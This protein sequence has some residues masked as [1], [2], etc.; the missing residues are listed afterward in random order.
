MPTTLPVMLRT[1][2]DFFPLSDNTIGHRMTILGG[3]RSMTPA[4]DVVS[5]RIERGLSVLI[6]HVLTAVRDA[7]PA[8][9]AFMG[10]S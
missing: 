9:A 6:A 2:K 8:Y 3:T 1:C 7:I 4:R 5:R 10:S